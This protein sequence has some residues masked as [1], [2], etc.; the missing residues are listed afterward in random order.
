M[1]G[2][3]LILNSYLA[4]LIF[5]ETPELSEIVAILGAICLGAPLVLESVRELIAGKL[6]MTELAALA[7]VSSFA[8]GYYAEAGL[9][10]FF[11]YMGTLIESRTALGARAAIEGLIRLTP[12]TAHL[13]GESGERDTQVAE[14]ETGDVFRVRP[15]ENVPADGII[16]GGSSSLNEASITGE[17]L[18]VDKA[19]DD[20]VFAGT[21]NFT[22]VIDVKVTTVGEDTTLGKVRH[23]IMEAE[24]T[25]LPLM[26][27]ID[28]NIQW[29][30]P[31]VL[32]ISAIIYFFTDSPTAAIAALVAACPCA[33]V[34]ATPTAMVAGLS[35][36]ARL[37]ILIKNVSHLESAGQLT[38][39]V[40]DKT[41]TLTTGVLE[42]S[43]LS[44]AEGIKP[45]E[46]LH[47]AASAEMHSNH[48]V[49]RALQRVSAEAKV[50]LS[51][52]VSM[53]ETS[54]KGVQAKVDS[55]TVL[56]G[57]EAWLGEQGISFEGFTGPEHH[58]QDGFSTLFVARDGA[59]I[60]WI[61]LEDHAR[62]EARKAT[63][64]LSELGIRNIT[65]LTGDR[66]GAAKRVASELGCT[67]VVAE[68]L[69]EQKLE[70]VESLKDRG[71]SVAVV[72]DGVN[73]A[74]AL[75]AGDLGIAM[76]AAG[77]DVAVNSASV[78]LLNNDLRRL[79]FMIRLSRMVRRVV[80]QNLVFGILFILTGIS[81]SAYGVLTPIG[82]AVLHC[83]GSLPVIFNSAR[84]VRYGEELH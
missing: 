1:L 43:R 10:A 40:C 82:A 57:R 80:Y 24:R 48:P 62:P 2:G 9:I 78:A 59:C 32:M 50:S 54:G 17:S 4:K 35:C 83:L 18:P 36:A 55:H 71:L 23:L 33:L 60:G 39:I 6:R 51:E 14:L 15:G 41:G 11:L 22:G 56:V 42:V 74:P 47:L 72:G 38:A 63:E 73:D 21:E 64:E 5:S 30:T 70:L 46:L 76:G 26:T 19:L 44:P 20:Q 58:E 3:A 31:T 28:Q 61:G 67:D 69:P 29:Y 84:I 8:L 77:S 45:E 75:A 66:W 16:V 7:V 68:C 13:V 34:M 25:R 52:P 81:L 65:M 53:E 49:A 12:Q 79:P 37:G 27:I